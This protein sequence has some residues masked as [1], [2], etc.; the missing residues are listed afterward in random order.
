MKSNSN[1]RMV[2]SVLLGL[3]LPVAGLVAPG[4]KK[5][6]P[7]PP[8]P[9]PTAE[10]TQETTLA[11]EPEDAG[12]DADADAGK[13]VVGTGRPASGLTACCNALAQNAKSAP[14]PN[15]VYMT[16]AAATCHALV[17]QGQ[18]SG[19]ILGAVRGALQGAGMPSSCR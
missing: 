18:A 19:T 9:T 7:P 14:P 3:F 17:A 8:L 16:Q 1:K 15:N 5:D 12:V 11:L 6:E 2:V 4:C 10:P 13:K